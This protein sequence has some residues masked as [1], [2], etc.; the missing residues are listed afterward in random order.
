M[1]RGM[2]LTTSVVIVLGVA[3]LGVNPLAA[4]EVPP[5]VP[6]PPTQITAAAPAPAVTPPAIDVTTRRKQIGL[7]EGLLTAAVGNGARE[8]AKQIQAVQPGLQ[9]FTGMARA[10]GFYL[11]G[12]GVFF[13]VEIPGVQPSVEW[14]LTTLERSRA[15]RQPGGQ[16]SLAGTRPEPMLDANAI[17]T[18]AVQQNLVSAMLDLRIDLLPDEWLTVAARDGAGPIGPGQIYET[19]TMVLR[20]KGSDVADFRAGRI[21]IEELRKKVEVREF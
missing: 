18:E 7:M 1:G 3:A 9:L 4:Q 12:Y 19:I 15:G 14:I 2:A 13:H 17:Y 21:S 8:T 16:A 10:R 6:P 11:E 20:V 5:T